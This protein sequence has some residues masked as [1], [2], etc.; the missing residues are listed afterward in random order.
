[1]LV[2][3]LDGDPDKPV[4]LGSIHNQEAPPPYALPSLN[5]QS[6]ITTRSSKGGGKDN[7]NLL[8]FEDKK[9]SEEVYIQAEYDM[10]VLVKHNL[11]T[12]VRDGDETRL[13][14]TGK[15]TTTIE[16]N[17]T[18]TVNTG[19]RETTIKTGNDTYTLSMG[20]LSQA[21][22]MGNYDLKLSMGNMSTALDMGSYSV[23]TSLGAVTIE[24]MQGITLKVGQSQVKLDQMGVTISG[25]MVKLDGKL[26]LDAQGMMTTVKG[27]AM[28][29]ASGAIV[30][31]G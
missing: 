13:V 27:N 24:A 18:L 16:G 21:L 20:N 4:V 26:Q 15:R 22:K 6:G 30:M 17:E 19:N 25:M 5:T 1:M 29:Q 2:G 8:R 7:A 9:G 23:K 31:I 12:T 3:F 14:K 10:N 11:D 28:L